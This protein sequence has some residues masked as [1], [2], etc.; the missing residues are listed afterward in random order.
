MIENLD[1]TSKELGNRSHVLL[2]ESKGEIVMVGKEEHPL[3]KPV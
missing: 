2:E 3:C 1:E